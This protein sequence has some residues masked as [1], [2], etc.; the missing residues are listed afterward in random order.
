[1]KYI[2]NS[3]GW[4]P[5]ELAQNYKDMNVQYDKQKDNI[6]QVLKDRYLFAVTESLL[7]LGYKELYEVLNQTPGLGT[8]NTYPTFRKHMN[9]YGSKSALRGIDS[10]DM[11][12]EIYKQ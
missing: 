10:I 11:S 8:H 2:S 5:R 4:L 7:K 12:Y 3:F 1:M 6:H 9:K